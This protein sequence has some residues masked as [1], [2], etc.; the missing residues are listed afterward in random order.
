M[1]FSKPKKT[2]LAEEGSGRDFQEWWTQRYGMINKRNRAFCV[3]CSASVVGRG[4]SV[5]GHY[6]SNHSWPLGKSE[7]EQKEHISREIKKTK[8]TN[9]FFCQVC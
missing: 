7:D 2:K 9:Q 1:S 6:G 4:S 3:M 8:L 5:K